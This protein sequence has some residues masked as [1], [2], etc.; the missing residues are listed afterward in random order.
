MVSNRLL[1]GRAGP[2]KR[3]AARA[4]VVVEG[5]VVGFVGDR[6]LVG[7]GGPVKIQPVA[8]LRPTAPGLAGYADVARLEGMGG[9]LQLAGRFQA[10]DRLR[11]DGC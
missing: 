7:G 3:P 10:G 8:D 1:A 5:V 6:F 2:G 4:R 11:L 9:S